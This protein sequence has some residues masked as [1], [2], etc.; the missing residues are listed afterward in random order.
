VFCALITSVIANDLKEKIIIAS[1][2]DI[3][4]RKY[5]DEEKEKVV[6]RIRDIKRTG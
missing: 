4:E 5:Q 3:T 2:E 1:L 6:G